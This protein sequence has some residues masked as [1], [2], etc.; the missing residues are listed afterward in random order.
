MFDEDSLSDNEYQIYLYLKKNDVSKMS[1]AS[2]AKKLFVGRSMIYRVC[3]KM[4]YQTFSEYK[5]AQMMSQQE[6]KQVAFNLASS[7]TDSDLS[8]L[9]LILKELINARH[10]YVAATSATAIAAQYLSRQLLNLGLFALVVSDYYEL[11]QRKKIFERG[12]VVLCISNSGKNEELNDQVDHLQQ[13]L[14][15]ITKTDSELHGLSDLAIHFNFE[16]YRY[17]NPFDRE[18]LFPIFVIIQQLLKSLRKTLEVID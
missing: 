18:N 12:D 6:H 17:E 15:A 10:V 4:R 8:D 11:K 3:K 14:I 1:A 16:D 9:N 7:L 13:T 2:I 5:Y